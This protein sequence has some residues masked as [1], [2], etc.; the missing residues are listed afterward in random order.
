MH[1]S[2]TRPLE[3][4]RRIDVSPTDSRVARSAA[5]TPASQRRSFSCSHSAV[6]GRSVSTRN[7]RKPSTDRRQALDEKEPLPAFQPQGAVEFQ[8]RL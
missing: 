6:S 5:I 1:S 8:E 7:E 4:L 2:H 3:K